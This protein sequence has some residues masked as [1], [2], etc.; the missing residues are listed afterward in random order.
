MPISVKCHGCSKTL[1]ISDDV[2]G[3][4]F[5]CNSCGTILLA[6]AQDDRTRS[7]ASS[8][9]RN[10]E[11][12][13]EKSQRG[14]R[15][16]SETPVRRK[17]P[18]PQMLSD[19]VDD[20][21]NDGSE[22]DEAEWHNS[23]SLRPSSQRPRRKPPKNFSKI[24]IRIG[25]ILL[26]IV[27][28]PLTMK[29]VRFLRWSVAGGGIVC[30]SPPFGNQSGSVRTPETWKVAG[31]SK[32][33][34]DSGVRIHFEDHAFSDHA[35]SRTSFELT[36]IHLSPEESALRLFRDDGQLD[37]E[38]LGYTGSGFPGAMNLAPP[39]GESYSTS[40]RNVDGIEF[41]R[42][43]WNVADS[44]V[45]DGQL[46]PATTHYF[47]YWGRREDVLILMAGGYSSG[48]LSLLHP[49]DAIAG[50]LQHGLAE[51]IVPAIGRRA[52]D[53]MKSQSNVPNNQ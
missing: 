12:G 16:K 6:V 53:Y 13:T 2:A 3:M 26:C 40:Y 8:A 29:A 49:A 18:E 5:R 47:T 38:V 42:I 39:E 4:R 28:I 24:L 27:A 44:M 17:K 14:N 31:V 32:R 20:E 15:G 43:S 52:S 23:T 25:I 7:N 10:K 45:R 51:A 48:N 37:P 50:T 19:Q 30:N 33:L 36:V 34:D 22:G 46:V 1:R 41:T 9:P 35:P 11:A 21:W